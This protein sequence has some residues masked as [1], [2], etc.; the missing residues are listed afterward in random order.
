MRDVFHFDIRVH[1]RGQSPF[2][3]AVMARSPQQ[4]LAIARIAYPGHFYTLPT[5]SPIQFLA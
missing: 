4:A 5:S 1:A 3:F 2:T